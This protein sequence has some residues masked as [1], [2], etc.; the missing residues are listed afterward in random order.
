MLFSDLN[1]TLLAIAK[2]ASIGIII[3]SIEQLSRRRFFQSNHLFSWSTISRFRSSLA[4]AKFIFP[5]LSKL[6][7]YP[8]VLWLIIA[9]ILAAIV[10][11]CFSNNYWLSSMAIWWIYISGLLLFNIRV[12]IRTG[13]SVFLQAIFVTLSL[14]RLVPNSELTELFCIWAIAIQCC[15]VYFENGITKL[16]EVEWRNGK[17]I[18]RVLN[19]PI[20]ISSISNWSVF[21]NHKFNRLLS[22]SVIM[23]EL[24]F[25]LALF[26]G[27]IGLIVLLSLGFTFHLINSWALGLGTFFWVFIA[28]YPAIIY[29]NRWLVE[30]L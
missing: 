3:N 30:Y 18:L 21:K 17:A 1:S 13:Y 29:C 5:L 19:N 22:W 10:L 25:P 7:D 14:Q 9:R 2:I 8:N 6:L 20:Y 26:G 16:K 15:L 12:I 23:F 11:F 24:T 27:N 4:H 28:A